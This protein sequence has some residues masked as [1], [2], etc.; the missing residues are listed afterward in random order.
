MSKILT[1]F[2]ATGN[3]GGSVIKAILADPILSKDFKIRGVT[4]DVSKP[5]AQALTAKGV[6][7]IKADMSSADAAFAA[8]QNAHTVFIVTN[9][10]ESMSD[11]VEIA[12]GK[13]VTDASLK[14]GVKHIIFSS[15]LNVTEA[16]KGR[17]SHV[18]HF[19]G[20]A[21]IEEY[22]RQ[23][24]IPATFVQP[25][26][27]MSGFTGFLRKQENGTY[28]WAMPE[29][30]KA[31][32]AKIPLFDAAGDSGIFV[33]AAIKN[34]PDTKGQRILA[35]TDYYTPSRI[36]S[37]FEN[38]MGKKASYAEVPHDVFKSFLPAPAAQELLENMLLLQ[39]PGYYAGADLKPSLALL[40]EDKPTTWK[41][42]VEENK[43]IW[44]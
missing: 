14:A 38:V 32:E 22:I 41:T 1:V 26:L 15:L 31:D 20:K 21:K 25:G 40:G 33:K 12:H 11:A 35:A 43:G 24:G 34:F 9:F 13:A 10:W 29:G 19:D 18:S 16:T 6:E 3:Q 23:S 39:E 7:M 28:M 8:V 37:E 30:V 2:G 5:A 17:L 42:F 36:I 27:F 44:A 4:R